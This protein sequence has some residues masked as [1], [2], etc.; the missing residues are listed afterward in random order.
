MAKH[1]VY[2]MNFA[3][4][5]PMLLQKVEKKG[6]TKYVSAYS[7]DGRSK[8]VILKSGRHVCGCQATKFKLVG[9]C[10]ACGRI[11]CEQEGLKSCK[12]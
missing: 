9:N 2:Q 4:V 8:D 5:Y 7:S 10:L 11:V 12:N 6:K 1:R 3:K